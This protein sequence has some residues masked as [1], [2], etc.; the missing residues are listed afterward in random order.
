M[1]KILIVN[2]NLHIGGVQRALVDL[3]K[4]I[5]DKY[6]ITLALF[7][8]Q[9]ALL[10]EVP[11]DVK[12][13]PIRSAY[14]YLG[15]SR[16]DVQSKPFLKL[17][18]S[19]YAAICRLFGRSVAISL[20]AMGQKKLRGFDVAISYLHDGGDKVFYG[21]C[22][23]F[24]LRHTDA[25]KKIA[26]LH[27]DYSMCGANT[28]KNAARY[29]KFNAIA[30]CSQGCADV[31]VGIL[32]DFS[33]KV[34]VVPNAH[35]YN[36]IRRSASAAAVTLPKGRVN[37]LTVAR[38]GKEK[39]VGRAIE[40][41][42]RLS[43][44]SGDFH[45][46]VIG[47]GILHPQIEA[48]IQAHGLTDRVTLLGEMENPYGYMQAADLLLIPSVSEAAPLVIHE[49]ACLGTAALSTRTSS[50]DEMIARNG[51]GWVCDNSVEGLYLALEELL[52]E[53]DALEKRK[54]Y[55]LTVRPDNEAATAC[56]E[57]LVT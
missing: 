5:H 14:R 3:L 40:A 16:Y 23:D 45:Y 54:N 33:K 21:G 31:F 7:H 42:A 51:F 20:M 1:K 11:E 15:L 27:C 28:A 53:P 43:Y 37:I 6:E 18:R 48:A 9:G 50:A 39:G 8:P 24:V 12:I 25:P 46:Y 17:R 41:L 30:A 29:E 56:F 26:F 19:F 49:A 52:T 47:D 2:N 22:N 38:L 35:D 34:V 10:E 36:N 4:E 57:A 44:V 55:L 32:P 13:L